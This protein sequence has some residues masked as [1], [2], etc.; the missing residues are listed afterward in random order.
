[1]NINKRVANDKLETDY[2]RKSK[3]RKEK[4]KFE[5]RTSKEEPTNLSIY[6]IRRSVQIRDE[7]DDS[8]SVEA[9]VEKIKGSKS[10]KARKARKNF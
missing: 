9:I 4:R 10:S 2:P 5:I 6:S 3:K 8:P 1:L 7:V